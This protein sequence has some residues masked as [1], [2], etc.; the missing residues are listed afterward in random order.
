MIS[1]V[2][3]LLFFRKS[4]L[5]LQLWSED[6]V[7]HGLRRFEDAILLPVWLLLH[8]LLCLCTTLIPSTH[9]SITSTFIAPLLLS[10]ALFPS[11]INTFTLYPLLALFSLG[12]YLTI[13]LLCHP[14]ILRRPHH[15][16]LLVLLHL[17]LLW[18]SL[19]FIFILELFLLFLYR[20]ITHFYLAI[21]LL[22]VELQLEHLLAQVWQLEVL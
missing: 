1:I 9:R 4:A 20:S 14:C 15:C 5:E 16:L 22:N 7:R 8:L 13:G 18:R 10:L 6:G 2:H 21:Q 11:S 3:Q 17:Q 12:N 19:F